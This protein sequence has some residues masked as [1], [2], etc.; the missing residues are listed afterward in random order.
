MQLAEYG[1]MSTRSLS[2]TLSLDDAHLRRGGIGEWDMNRIAAALGIP[3]GMLAAAVGVDAPDGG[4]RHD[5]AQ[6][7]ASPSR[8]AVHERL[9]LFVNVLLVLH[10]VFAGDQRQI[11][12]WL[13]LPH[14]A[15]AGDTPLEVLLR[16]GMASAVEQWVIRAWLGDPS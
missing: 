7:G 6:P 10:D 4:A 12:G 2:E 11:A 3:A 5:D 8:A 9:T 13:R 1:A 14:D 16:P 15:L